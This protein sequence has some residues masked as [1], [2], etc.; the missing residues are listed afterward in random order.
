MYAISLDLGGTHIG[1]AVVHDREVLAHTSIPANARAGLAP[2][3]PH[4]RSTLNSLLAEA[5]VTAVQCSG[6]AMGYPGIVD[7]R[8]STIL[9]THKKYEDA[10]HLDLAGWALE[11]FGLPIRMENDA[12]MALLG[13]QFAGAAQHYGDVVMMTLGTG[14]GTGAMIN[15]HLLRGRHAQAGNL[16]GHLPVDFHGRHCTCGNIGCAEAE[17]SGWA[18]PLVAQDWPG[19]SRSTLAALP[20]VSFRQ[21]FDHAAHGDQVA[22][23]VQQHCL[24]VWASNAV[25]N[26]HAY[27]PE[28]VVIGGGV[29]ESAHLIIPFLQHH[30]DEHVWIGG[31]RP[32]ILPAKLGNLAGLI[33]A[34]PLLSED[35]SAASL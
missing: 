3:L 26:I 31:F 5:S 9:S 2:L 4:L 20:H 21:L 17:A 18:L 22:L 1:C 6:I 29:I 25:A 11:N 32:K 33:G 7:F 24:E 15:G 14:I 13:E 27:D 30:V 35:V 34:V 16:G 12:R 19:F 8:T 28:I 10:I 23:A